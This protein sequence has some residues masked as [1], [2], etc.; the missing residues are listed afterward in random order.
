MSRLGEAM[1]ARAATFM[2]L[3]GMG[4]LVLTCTGDLSRN[5]QV[6]LRLAAGESTEAISASMRMVAEGVKTTG[7][8]CELAGQL[9]VELPLAFA[10]RRVLGGTAPLDALR[11]LMSRALREE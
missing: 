5:R 10:V 3:S 8:V 4:D 6:G 1:G 7:A 11:D 2:G 9:N